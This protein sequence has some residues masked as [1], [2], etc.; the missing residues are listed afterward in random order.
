MSN[1]NDFRKIY[2]ESEKQFL[3]NA[4]LAE[5]EATNGKTEA[6]SLLGFVLGFVVFILIALGFLYLGTLIQK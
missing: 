1:N 5:G 4:T 6:K 2:E 3:E